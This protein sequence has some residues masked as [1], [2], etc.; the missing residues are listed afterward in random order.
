[1]SQPKIISAKVSEQKILMCV[2]VRFCLN[3]LF[4]KIC[5]ISIKW[6][7]IFLVMATI[8]N[9]GKGG[10]VGYNFKRGLSENH[11]SQV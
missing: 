5:T 11:P 3:I 4:I 8:L 2:C 6:K 1:M 7:S 10:A 9:R